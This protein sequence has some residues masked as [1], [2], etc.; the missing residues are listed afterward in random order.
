[1]SSANLVNAIRVSKGLDPNQDRRLLGV[2]YTTSVVP[3]DFNISLY[4]F[5]V[6][7][8]GWSATLFFACYKGMNS[9]AEPHLKH[10]NS[11]RFLGIEA[12][13]DFCKSFCI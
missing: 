2:S 7:N 5:M 4:A 10:V 1:M 6:N 13:L 12:R 9:C 3:L 11:I 8:M